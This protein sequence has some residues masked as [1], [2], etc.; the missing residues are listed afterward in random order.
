MIG[1]NVDVAVTIADLAGYSIPAEAQVDGRSLKPVLMEA[2]SL[3]P[4]GPSAPAATTRD[5]FMFE[6]SGNDIAPSKVPGGTCGT[7]WMKPGG[8]PIQTVPLCKCG[9]P[10]NHWISAANNTYTGLRILNATHNYK[11]VSYR[12]SVGFEELF[13]LSKDKHE[14]T[15]IVKVAPSGI[16]T[17]MR[18]RLAQLRKCGAGAGQTPCP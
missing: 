16:A 13:D 11:F 12:D 7:A 5:E 17:Y 15:N 18:A 1:L 2:R 4:S 3:S 14:L 10:M 9:N 6:H 8:K